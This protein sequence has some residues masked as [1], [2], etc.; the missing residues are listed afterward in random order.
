[1]SVEA[2]SYERPPSGAVQPAD[3]EVAACGWASSKKQGGHILTPVDL[4]VF[5]ELDIIEPLGMKRRH[6]AM[7]RMADPARPTLVSSCGP[8]CEST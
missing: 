6:S 3:R 7:L 1:V 5:E 8:P 2:L 4:I